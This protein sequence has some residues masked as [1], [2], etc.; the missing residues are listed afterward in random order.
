MG[1]EQLDDNDKQKYREGQ[2]DTADDKK[3]LERSVSKLEIAIADAEESVDTL[4]D[5][6]AA[7]TWGIKDLDEPVAE[8]AENREEENSDFKTLLASDTAARELLAFATND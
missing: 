1:K 8:A 6:I 4:A 3:A 2:F 7:L 5:E